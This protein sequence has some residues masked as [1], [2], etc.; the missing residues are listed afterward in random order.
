MEYFKSSLKSVLGAQDPSQQPTGAEVVDRLVERVQSCTLLEDRRGACRTIK[1]LSKKHRVHVGA[2]GMQALIGVLQTDKED[3]EIIGYALDT[4]CNIMSPTVFEEEECSEVD[5]EAL[6]HVGEQF[7]E[8][9]LKETYNVLLVLNFLEEY[10]FKVR[11][12][13]LKLLTILLRNRLRDIQEII[14]VSPMGV[15]KL[16]D[17]LS[18]SREVIRNDTL[19]LLFQLTKANANIQ[20]IVAFENAFDRL[21][22]VINEEGCASGGI[23]VEDCLLVMVNLLKNNTSNQNFFKEGSYIKKL[24][25]LFELSTGNEETWPPQK[26]ANLLCGLQVIRCLISPSNSAQITTACQ[27]ILYSSGI[28]NALSS[29]LMSPSVHVNFLTEAIFTLSEMIRGNEQNQQHF[30]T[31]MAPSTPPREAIVVL[32]TSMVNEKQQLGLRC[33]A[34]YCF[35]CY[36][37]K[38]EVG[39]AQLLQTLMLTSPT[40][41]NKVTS[42]QLLCTSMFSHDSLSS[43]LSSVGLSYAL[44]ENPVQKEQLLRVLIAPDPNSSP[45]T[46]IHQVS[47]LMQQTNKVQ[48]KLGI[49]ILLATWLSHCPLAVRH[50]L[51]VPTVIPY[52]TAQACS[53]ERDDNEEL[54]QG[55]C[56]FLFGICIIFN[57]GSISVYTKDSLLLIINNR[58]GKELFIAKMGE[59]SKHEHYSKAAKQ[60]FPRATSPDELLLDYEFCK[61]FKVLESMIVKALISD[62]ST[63][64]VSGEIAD[65]TL[66]SEYKNLIRDQDRKIAELEAQCENLQKQKMDLHSNLEQLTANVARMSDENTLLRAQVN[67]CGL[68]INTDL[69]LQLESWKNECMRKDS[70]IQDLEMKLGQMH[71][72]QQQQQQPQH[73][74]QNNLQSKVDE[75]QDEV[76]RLMKDQE[77]LLVLLADKEKLLT[78]YSEKLKSLGIKVEEES[79]EA[80]AQIIHDVNS[81]A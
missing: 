43:W 51:E 39:Q 56:A 60:P 35:Q 1:A 34:L 69:N 68:N 20:K 26:V 2:Q 16:M 21:F 4:L 37:F 58:I 24:C 44:I 46:L 23:V 73:P 67:A 77:D 25:P 71:L 49:L 9:F 70:T 80:P 66:V 41:F 57:D 42:G 32:L 15:S 55:L 79:C 33:A 18:D 59:V 63:I 81:M 53:S 75:L 65:S 11:W 3:C 50:F 76:D 30:S 29:I 8:I 12:P 38:N 31:I 27:N 13:A 28:F 72:H 14:L 62:K 6:L 74:T 10:D 22:D 54:V 36:L 61:L 47:V 40:D 17:L 5:Q 7:T 19:L 52:L 64:D 78:T 48:G 45:V